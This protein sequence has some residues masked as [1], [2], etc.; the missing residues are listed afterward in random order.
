MSSRIALFVVLS[1]LT[2]GAAFAADHDLD[3][4]PDAIDKC[5]DT[6]FM[7]TV[8]ASGCTVSVLLLPKDSANDT[9]IVKLGYGYS[10]DEEQNENEID[11]KHSVTVR[12]NYYR[13]DWLFSARTGGL[14]YDNLH[15]T[16]DTTLKIAKRFKPIKDLRLYPG[17]ALKFPTRK[18]QGNRTDIKFYLSANYSLSSDTTVFGGYTYTINRDVNDTQ[19]LQNPSTFYLGLGHFFS[20]TFYADFSVDLTQSIYAN[21][22]IH[23]VVTASIFYQVTPRLYLTSEYSHEID[24]QIHDSL[25]FSI[26][27]Y[28]W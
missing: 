2:S 14:S 7:N 5:P 21:V 11:K 15:A 6:P 12:L 8:D 28:L 24:S 18:R 13:D 3:G 9:L 17:F 4:V 20:D 1:F 10:R 27:Y 26:G 16:S 19:R 23:H 25:G 22:P